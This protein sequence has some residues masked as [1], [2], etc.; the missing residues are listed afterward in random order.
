MNS[1]ELNRYMTGAGRYAEL[2]AAVRSFKAEL[3]HSSLI[4]RLVEAGSLSETVNML[5]SGHVTGAS[6]SDLSSI[7]GYL[8][9]NVIDIAHRLAAYAPHDSRALIKLLA[10]SHEFA[11]IKDIVKSIADQV[12]P[13]EAI[14]NI[15][16]AGKFTSDKCK[17]LIESHNLTKVIETLDDEGL[18]RFMLPKLTSDRGGMLAVSTLDQYYY[19]RLWAASNLPDPLDAQSARVL[20]GQAIDHLNIL[21]SFRARLMGLDTRST[22]EMMIPVNYGLGRAFIELGEATNL[23]NLFGVLDKTPYGSSVRGLGHTEGA[24]LGVERA[25]DR[26]HAGACL[27]AFA[28]SPFNVGLAIAFLFL[29]NYELHD[30]FTILNGK[31]NNVPADVMAESLILGGRLN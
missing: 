8:V 23:Q 4:N 19:S 7:E 10:A 29:K 22:S 25:L 24:A 12:D 28:G 31:A 26:D 11:C 20:V 5:T 17:E 27:N 9:Q 14:R 15:V 13:E 30:F 6:S 3:V 21:L 16:P 1:S 18:R 2:A